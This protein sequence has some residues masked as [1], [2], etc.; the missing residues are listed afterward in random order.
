MAARK[1]KNPFYVLLL[2]VGA[3]FC[4]TAF[5]YGF[6]AFQA[7]NQVGGPSVEHAAHPLFVWLNSHGTSALVVELA[8][9]ALLT[10][11]AIGTDEWWTAKQREPTN[12]SASDRSGG[13]DSHD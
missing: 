7:V 10:I 8:A 11:G 6:M 9:L 5:A 13:G 2:P 4:V 3:V 1:W 12:H